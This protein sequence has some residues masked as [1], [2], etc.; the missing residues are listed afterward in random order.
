MNKLVWKLLRRHIS[1]GQLAGFFLASLFGM[2]VILLSVQGYRDALPLFTAEDSFMRHDYLVVTKRISTIGSLTGSSNTFTPE[3]IQ[4]LKE[5]SFTRSIGIFTPS[6]FDV[7]AGVGMEKAGIRLSTDMFFESVPDRYID[8]SSSQWTFAPGDSIIP[9]II[10]RNY[11][12]LYNFG[13]AQSRNLPKLSEGVMELIQMQVMLRGNGQTQH[14]QG[15]IVG[16]SNRLNTILVPQSFM[17]WANQT[18][19]PGRETRPSRV[20][21]EVSNPADASLA[22]YFQQHHYETEG[23]SL[24]AG[25]TTYFL[26]LTTGVVTGIGLF[27]SVLS[28]YILMLSIFLLLQKNAAKL[29]YLLLLGYSATQVSRPYTALT[30]GLSLAVWLLST[31]LVW[32]MRNL[33]LHALQT[34]FPT[35]ETGSFLPTWIT[36]F[37]LTVLMT[38]LNCWIIRR[39][40]RSLC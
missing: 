7:S 38:V 24:D 20:I 14:F 32:S 35:L 8:V 15:Q 22:D 1:I 29:E 10:P 36:G 31:G 30:V 16:F 4:D 28:F 11:L 13:F 17:N 26:R 2:T 9:I 18:F 12:N 19:A 21:V 6:L 34:L 40:I 3:D 39:K 5:Q 27:I 23:N 33:Y 25:K 37:L